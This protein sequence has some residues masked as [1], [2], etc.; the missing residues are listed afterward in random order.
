MRS[1]V[2]RRLGR[3][4]VGGITQGAWS[5]TEGKEAHVCAGEDNWAGE[6]G[7]SLSFK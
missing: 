3:L 6:M 4:A 2:R 1:G 5:V 7:R